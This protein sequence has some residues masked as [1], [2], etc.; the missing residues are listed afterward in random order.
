MVSMRG[1]RVKEIPVIQPRAQQNRSNDVVMGFIAGGLTGA[2]L[3]MHFGPRVAAELRTRYQQ[4]STRVGAAVDELSRKVNDLSRKGESA[5]DR[6]CDTVA[7]GAREVERY[8]T[9][10]QK[11]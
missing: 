3:A 11:A 4:V 6:L 10:A 9:E 8:A 7:S 2:A 5:R 1:P